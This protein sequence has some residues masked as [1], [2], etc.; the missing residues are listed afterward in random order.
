MKYF[1][2]ELWKR[3]NSGDRTAD[4]QWDA[5]CTEYQ[6]YL[7][8]LTNR[9]DIQELRNM[10]REY[11][12]FHDYDVEYVTVNRK[13]RTVIIS[14]QYYED[15]RIVLRFDDVEKMNL[16]INELIDYPLCMRWGYTELEA[17]NKEKIGL[18]VIFDWE[19]EM[20]IVFR[21]MDIKE[22]RI[23]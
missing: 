5:N 2:G 22:E 1:T 13:E 8:S 15:T 23:E 9:R 3:I 14:L 7:D 4:K 6:N 18:S 11:R 19:N 10:L 20:K 16:D 21:N 17:Y 12:G